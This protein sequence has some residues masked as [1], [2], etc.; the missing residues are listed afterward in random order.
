M[1]V[2]LFED[3]GAAHADSVR[4]LLPSCTSS[5]LIL[6]TESLEDVRHPTIAE[7]LINLARSHNLLASWQTTLLS[8]QEFVES[9]KVVCARL[10]QE[11]YGDFSVPTS[12]V[13]SAQID[14][15]HGEDSPR[16]SAYR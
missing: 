8:Y 6:R 14:Y 10:N 1:D 5:T 16:A 12:E 3:Y 2:L 7:F 13:I 4:R 11:E 15:A 9:L